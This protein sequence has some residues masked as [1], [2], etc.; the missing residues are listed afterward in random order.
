MSKSDTLKDDKKNPSSPRSNNILRQK[1]SND[2]RVFDNFCVILILLIIIK[3]SITFDLKSAMPFGILDY[4]AL[5][6]TIVVAITFCYE[7]YKWAVRGD[8][9]TSEEYPWQLAAN[10][11]FPLIFL[12]AISD[13][14]IYP[15]AFIALIYL[16]ALGYHRRMPVAPGDIEENKDNS[17]IDFTKMW[18]GNAKEDSG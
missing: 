14:T 2:M 12:F 13:A 7:W 11:V 6:F 16:C 3:E 15:A 18:R 5:A 10:L 4:G 1:M 9:D 17:F 8:A